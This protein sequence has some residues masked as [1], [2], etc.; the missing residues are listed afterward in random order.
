MSAAAP[1]DGVDALEPSTSAEA[2]PT[3]GY[4]ATSPS[5]DSARRPRPSPMS[6]VRGG[7]VRRPRV[8]QAASGSV[9]GRDPS[10][11]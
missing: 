10:R 4:A 7:K 8:A 9:A 11:G 2:Q 1:P 5:S 3:S 6:D